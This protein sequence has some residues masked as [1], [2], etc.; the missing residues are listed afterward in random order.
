MFS[1]AKNIKINFPSLMIS[2]F[3]YCISRNNKVGYGNLVSTTLKNNQIKLPTSPSFD[4]EPENSLTKDTLSRLKL[5]V[6]GGKLRY[7]IEEPT[8]KGTLGSKESMRKRS[9]LGSKVCSQ[10]SAFGRD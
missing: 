1:L 3:L 6:Q 5:R 2:H 7:G 4:L 9:V 10:E 8:G